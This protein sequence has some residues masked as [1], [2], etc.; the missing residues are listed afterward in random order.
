LEV[1]IWLAFGGRARLKCR[2]TDKMR[3]RA[4]ADNPIRKG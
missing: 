4:G 1:V 3:T 2:D